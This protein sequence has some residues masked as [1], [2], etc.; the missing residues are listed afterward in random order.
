M[1]N[2]PNLVWKMAIGI[3][4]L[5]MGLMVIGPERLQPWLSDLLRLQAPESVPEPEV[6]RA[7]E[8]SGRV[9]ASVR[10]SDVRALMAEFT[11]HGS[12]VVGYEGH[13]VAA[14][15]IESEF[16]RLGLEDVTTETYDVASP[17]D[18]GGRLTLLETGETFP[19]HGVWPNLVKTSTLPRGGIRSRLVYGGEGQFAD[20]NGHDMDGVVVLMEFNTWNNWLNAAMLGARQVIFIEPDS[21]FTAQAEQKFLQVPNSVERFWIDKESGARLRALL[22]E[23]GSLNVDMRARMDWEKHDVSNI[24]G[25][26]RGS[27]P[28]LREKIVVINAYYDAMSV[29]PALA[30]GAEM[31]SGIVGLMKLA[32][33]FSK[34]PPMHTVLFLASSAHH[35]GFRGICDFLNR[36]SRKEKNFASLMTDPIDIP[37]FIS[38]DLSSQTDAVGVWNSTHNFY[39]KRFFTPFGRSFVRYANALSD[40]FGLER[41][42]AL[43]DGINPVGGMSWEMYIPGKSIKTDGEVVLGAG[44]P[45]LSLVTVNDARFRVDTPLDKPEYINYANLTG[46]IRTITGVL[47]LA[48][49]TR[50]FLPD[51][52]L[53]PND[54]MRGLHGF[55]RTFPRRSITPDRPRSGAIASLRTGIDKSVKGVRSIYYDITDENGEFFMP[56]IAD[57]RVA[58]QAHYMDPETGNITY[59]PNFGQQ[60]R[61]YRGEFDMNWWISKRT[62]IMFPCVS[63]DFYDTVDPRYLTKLSQ[64]SVYGPNNTAPQEYGFSIGFGPDEP[65]GVLFTTQGDR[66]KIAMRSGAIGIRYLLLNAQGSDSEEAARG[67][68]L[69]TLQHGAF[70]RTSFQAAKDMWML[71]ESRIRDLKQFSIENQRLD[72]LHDQARVHL[73]LAEQAMADLQWDEFVKQTRAAMGIE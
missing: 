60:A 69:L 70:I 24:L 67:I 54:L 35:L 19:I 55:V 30:P 6:P 32:A 5:V 41:G 59:A 26:V 16:R 34:H 42:A 3:G 1:Q 2:S 38:L 21:T 51:Y 31:A 64:I 22:A 71:N 23:Q 7:D 53:E 10:E 62:I 28:E 52:R 14:R 39:Y 43:V 17:V 49:N 9:L 73:E 18:K 63:T 29:V 72:A 57:R 36:H 68:G 37:L 40:E 13:D 11:R 48:L 4:V 15:Y 56:G 46:Q 25:W 33:Y 27:D 8:V 20:F 44:T 66:V 47:D 65:V 61:I 50:T 45:A 12:R 58:V